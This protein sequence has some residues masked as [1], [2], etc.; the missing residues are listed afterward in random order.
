MEKP[1]NSGSS[2][3]LLYAVEKEAGLLYKAGQG[4]GVITYR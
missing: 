1:Q 2:A 3:C 4:S